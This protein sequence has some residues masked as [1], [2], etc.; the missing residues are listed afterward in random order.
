[1]ARV[2]VPGCPHLI[3]Q[4]GRGGRDIFLSTADRRRFL[5][6]L[7]GYSKRKGLKVRAYALLP[8]RVSVVAV[9]RDRLSLAFA[10]KLALRSYAKYVK[11]KGLRRGRVWKSRFASCP[12]DPQYCRE[13]M[14]HVERGPVRAG[15][16]SRA[17]QYRWSS[18]AAH[19]GNRKDPVPSGG[20][21]KNWAAWLS[22]AG[23]PK[24]AKL[25]ERHTRT[26]RPLGS[27]EFIRDLERRFRRRFRCRKPGPPRKKRT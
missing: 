8:N 26:G 17:E 11:K 20:A 2:V 27:K 15:L 16:V 23:D 10:L 4:W 5:K 21:V 22:E 7:A 3:T 12:I 9:P 19:C 6:L 18:A 14:R 24:F 25:L 13:A 1:M